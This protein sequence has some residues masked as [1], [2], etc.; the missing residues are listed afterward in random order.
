MGRWELYNLNSDPGEQGT[1]KSRPTRSEA[2]R[3]AAQ[4]RQQI[5]GEAISKK[6]LAAAP[7]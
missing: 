7:V 6:S 1:G 2:E 5:P 4:M 3:V